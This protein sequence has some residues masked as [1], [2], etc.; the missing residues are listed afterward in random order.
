MKKEFTCIECPNG[1]R[2]C[3]DVKDGKAVSVEG[4]KCPKGEKYALAEIENPTRILTSVVLAEGL[5]LKMVPVK[6]SQA[7]PKRLMMVAVDEIKKLKI[8]QAV[9]VGDVIV[10]N[11]LDTDADLIATRDS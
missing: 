6:T 1:C 5:S 10:K 11:F 3:V 7:I 8:T 4:F 9:K 2:L